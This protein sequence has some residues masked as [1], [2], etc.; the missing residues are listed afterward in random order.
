MVRRNKSKDNKSATNREWSTSYHVPSE[1]SSVIVC[2]DTFLSILSVGRTSVENAAKLMF[3]D[4]EAM[5]ETRGGA[6]FSEDKEATKEK[7]VA[8]IKQLGRS[9]GKNTTDGTTVL[10]VLT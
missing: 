9:V 4:D 1:K 5:K 6:R 10:A 8:H 3:V 2:K 7:I